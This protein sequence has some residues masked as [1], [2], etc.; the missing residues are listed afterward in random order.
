MVYSIK[1]SINVMGLLNWAL[2]LLFIELNGMLEKD[3]EAYSI[4]KNKYGQ[5]LAQV[6][7]YQW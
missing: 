3:F 1:F 6:V 7:S 2:S 4:C 5:L